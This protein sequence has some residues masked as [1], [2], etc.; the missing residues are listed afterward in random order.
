MTEQRRPHPETCRS[1]RGVVADMCGRISAAVILAALLG[2]Q[3]S[4]G[5][6]EK[7]APGHPDR[8]D[9]D[10]SHA[11]S[12]RIDPALARRARDLLVAHAP[13]K[14]VD[15]V[16][17]RPDLSIGRTP[18]AACDA[19]LFL[20]DWL[21]VS[22]GD[23]RARRKADELIA[24]VTGLQRAARATIGFAGVP[25]TP[26]LPSPRDSFFYAI[27]AAICGDAMLAVALSTA[28]LD[29]FEAAT[30][31]GDFLLMMA[32][33]HGARSAKAG[34]QGAAAFCEHATPAGAGLELNCDAYLKNAI[35]LG[36][37]RRLAAL[38]GDGRYAA[39]AAAA[40]AFFVEGLE[41]AWEYAEAPSPCRKSP[42]SRVWR[43]I[44]GSH[45]ER[46]VFVYGD[47]LA[48]GLRGLFEHE[49]ASRTVRHLY[50]RLTGFRGRGSAT[51]AFDGRIA[52]AG[53]L[54]PA[55]WEPDPRSAYYDLVTIGILGPV[56]RAVAPGDGRRAADFL[57]LLDLGRGPVPWA[58]GFEGQ[59]VG[60]STMDLTTVSILGRH[61]LEPYE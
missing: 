29:A 53:Y 36:F 60:L 16:R 28:R 41:G 50:W 31:F 3:P 12:G 40:R 43:R 9:L 46:D 57:R 14:Q 6:G 8:A 21:R 22:P 44:Q 52:L 15:L 1:L 17:S 47:T 7:T 19:I 58:I 20:L 37:L 35:S 27:D 42:C 34:L 4:S 45:G 61:A 55:T 51:S 49:G 56:R 54:M 24:W 59:D 25:S 38:S 2:C 13:F 33:E 23:D 48:Y 5:A 10:A 26:D 18:A 39:S 30:G 11:P 32:G